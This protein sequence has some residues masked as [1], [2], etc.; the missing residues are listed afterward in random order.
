MVKKFL[1]RTTSVGAGIA[2]TVIGVSLAGVFSFVAPSFDVVV[3]GESSTATSIEEKKSSPTYDA[4]VTHLATPEPMYAIYMSQCVA[5]TKSF[6]EKLV[7]M[8]DETALNAVVI[9]IKDYSGTI[10][11]PTT[12]SRFETVSM[13]SCGAGDMK[14]FIK[15]LHEKG[16]YVIGRVTVFQDPSYTKAHPEQAVQ[17]VARPGEPWKDHKGLSFVDVSSEPYWDYIATLSRE[18]YDIGFDELNY[19]YVRYP[20]DGPMADASYVN[21]NKAE[22]LEKFFKYLHAQVHP[23]GVV[24]SV[25]LFGYVTVLTDDLGIGQVLERAL[26]YFDYVAPM[27]YPSHYNKGFVGLANP[28]SDPYKVVYSSMVEAVKRAEAVETRVKTLDGQI[29]FK[30]EEVPATETTATTTKKVASGFYTKEAH[31]R[32]KLRPWLQ[33]F[34]Y[35]KD[36]TKEDIEA[37]IQATYDSGLT[38]WFFW[39]PANKYES[40]YQWLVANE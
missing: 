30:D 34:D 25:D 6:R 35:G 15:T 22:A 32:L 37:Q 31:S 16:I 11:F 7:S 38:S 19:D 33:D 4:S 23:T 40:L 17:S 21:N 3:P 12:D 2:F 39:D 27:V 13:V 5:G 36:Y 8:I 28:N 14:T 10:G 24:M 18:A 26:P 29:I 1:K 9:D 20:S